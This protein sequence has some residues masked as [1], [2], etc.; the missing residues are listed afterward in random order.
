MD[1]R[2]S[3]CIIG[4]SHYLRTAMNRI[5]KVISRD[6]TKPTEI[7]NEIREEL[8]EKVSHSKSTDRQF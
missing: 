6:T 2:V 5:K 7:S 8:T 4:F 3:S 1:T